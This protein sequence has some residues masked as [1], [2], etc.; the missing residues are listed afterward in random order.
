MAGEGFAKSTTEYVDQSTQRTALTLTCLAAFLGWL[1]DGFEQG[2]FPVVARPALLS[3][4]GP[5]G[6]GAIGFWMGLITAAFLV[7][8]AFGG[9]AF[10]WLGDRIGRVRA[11]S[12]S[13]LF[14]SLFSGMGYFVTSAW[15]LG[16]FR[17][18]SALGMG[19]EW[20]LGVAL[21]MEVWP[22][23]FRPYLAGM[24]GAAA[25][26]GFLLIGFIAAVFPVTKD[27]WRW[28]FLVG[29]T[30]ALLTFFIRLFVPESEKWKQASKV[31]KERARVSP[32]R[33]II[34]SG[35][36]GRAFIG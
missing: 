25:N 27:S 4:L 19:G 34:R 28:M 20:A 14:Y 5:G 13:I 26:V 8:A 11:M 21:V 3:L 18:L 7:G 16:I 29:A 12:L 22:E 1:F 33:E 10:G 31:V 2:L 30:P 17:F 15:Q 23:K 24:I 6:E 9:F 36:A 35:L 32:V